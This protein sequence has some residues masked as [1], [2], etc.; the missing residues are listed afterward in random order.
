MERTPVGGE[1]DP[2]GVRAA[3]AAAQE[4][5]RTAERVRQGVDD[6]RQRARSPRGEVDVQ[7]DS[8]GRIVDLTF[9]P[10]ATRLAPAALATLLLRTTSAAEREARA[11]VMAL[12]REGFGDS[13]TAE[14]IAAS[15]PAPA[16]RTR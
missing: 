1:G 16:A 2:G 6:V 14:S 8:L 10:G 4:R 12:V 5:A 13:A 3:I 7:V 15:W 9:G 11:R